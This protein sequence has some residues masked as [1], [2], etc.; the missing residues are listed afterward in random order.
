MV[1]E[2]ALP[3]PFTVAMLMVNSLTIL[4][5]IS[6][7]IR[8][9]AEALRTPSPLGDMAGERERSNSPRLSKPIGL[10][11]SRGPLNVALSRARMIPRT[12]ARDLC[13][14]RR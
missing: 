13:G 3:E 9:G 5:D 4:E 10:R 1:F 7:F 14:P 2:E 6:D 11:E 8:V 12:P